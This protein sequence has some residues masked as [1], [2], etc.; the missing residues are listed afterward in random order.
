MPPFCLPRRV[1]PI[2]SGARSPP[3]RRVGVH[4]LRLNTVT[5]LFSVVMATTF[6]SRVK[7]EAALQ[8]ASL[9]PG[10]STAQETVSVPEFVSLIN[11]SEFL[12]ASEERPSASTEA[13]QAAEALS[14]RFAGSAGS[15]SEFLHVVVQQDPV[16]MNVLDAP[17]D[18]EKP[19]RVAV[20]SDDDAA[21]VG[22]LDRSKDMGET[23]KSEATAEPGATA[24]SDAMMRL[25]APGPRRAKS[26]R[27][28]SERQSGVHQH[29][30]RSVAAENTSRSRSASSGDGADT[31]RLVGF[32]G[33][34]AD[35]MLSN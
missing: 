6:P 27:S 9:D 33:L 10:R 29:G 13:R 11:L 23:Q 17:K 3:K 2:R 19:P 12:L 25:G 26:V 16:A 4:I 5:I 30:H 31:E 14:A 28:S 18:P 35:Q 20:T 22:N 34:S 32:T 7:H 21:K 8:D 15:D 1:M 24:D